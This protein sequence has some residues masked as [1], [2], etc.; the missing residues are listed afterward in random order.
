MKEKKNKILIINIILIIIIIIL[1]I[2]YNINIKQLNSK[3]NNYKR[4]EE[5]YKKTELNRLNYNEK[6]EKNE[7]I[8]LFGDSITEIYPVD[9]IFSSYQII[10]SGTSGYTTDDLLNKI[11]EML[12]K[13]NPT[14]VML[15]IGTNDIAND[16]SLEKQKDTV[17]NI[18]KI[19][20]EI[21]KNRPNAKIYIE[22]IYPVNRNMKKDMVAERTNEVIQNMNNNIKDYCDR[23]K[24][25]YINM[26]DEL[27]DKS[28]N[29]DENYTY[30][31]LHP[32]TLG[33]AKIS[34]VLTQY[35]YE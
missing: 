12:Y 19:C 26:Y 1:L 33:Y 28:G 10:K 18:K 34:R 23:E 7:N 9:E 31:G 32:S 29:F 20:T 8:V 21:R 5:N 30:D 6:L 24:L 15:L 14:K 22:S 4:R 17:N 11:E 3:I 27:T 13:Y 2:I 25:T 16:I 35:I